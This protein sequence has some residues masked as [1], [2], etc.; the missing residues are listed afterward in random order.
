MSLRASKKKAH[1]RL[2]LKHQ[3]KH[4]QTLLPHFPRTTLGHHAA[5]AQAQKRVS[6]DH[7]CDGFG[8]GCT[9]ELQEGLLREV[10]TI[11]VHTSLSQMYSR[12]KKT[13]I[14]AS[15]LFPAVLFVPLAECQVPLGF[16]RSAPIGDSAV[17]QYR[18]LKHAAKTPVPL[19]RSVEKGLI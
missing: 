1:T 17:T 11:S 8:K 4:T 13:E 3:L 19:A 9:V 2:A 5:A 16:C 14:I 10:R 7:E 12:I 6:H 15:A 18:L